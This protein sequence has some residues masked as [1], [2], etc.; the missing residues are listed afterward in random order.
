METHPSPPRYKLRAVAALV[1]L[2]VGTAM[3]WSWPWGVLF[4]SMTLPTIRLGQTQLVETV[5]RTRNPVLFWS[6]TA[7]WLALSAAL[8]GYDLLH[9][10]AP[11]AFASITGESP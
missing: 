6:I 11:V 8:I 3:G 1:V 10:I 4:I 7:T 2:C 9:V 5:T